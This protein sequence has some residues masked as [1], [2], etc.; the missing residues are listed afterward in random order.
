MNSAAPVRRTPNSPSQS[1][2]LPEESASYD[3]LPPPPYV[4]LAY[5][6]PVPTSPDVIH[7]GHRDGRRSPDRLSK[8]R[9]S[10]FLKQS[11]GPPGVM[12]PPAYVANFGAVQ[13]YQHQTLSKELDVMTTR[14]INQVL[15]ELTGR[16]IRTDEVSPRDN[17]AGWCRSAFLLAT[18]IVA[19]AMGSLVSYYVV[20]N[21]VIDSDIK[22]GNSSNVIHLR[23]DLGVITVSEHESGNRTT[24]TS[25]KASRVFYLN[26][27]QEE[28]TL[29]FTAKSLVKKARCRSELCRY[30]TQR[31]KSSLNW[32]I[33]PCKDFYD[34]VCASWKTCKSAVLSQDSA[35]V[36]EIQNTL[37]RGLIQKELESDNRSAIAHARELFSLCVKN[38]SSDPKLE[39]KELTTLLETVGL[40]NW[41]YRNDTLSRADFWRTNAMLYRHLDLSALVSVT[42]ERDPDNDTNSIIALDE[43]DLLIGL[44]GTKEAYLPNWYGDV[45][46]VTMKL[47][48]P[49]KYLAH[50]QS[51]LEFSEKLSEITSS[52]GERNYAEEAKISTIQHF[53]SYAQFL[54]FIFDEIAPVTERTRI[55]VKNVRY[56]KALKSLLHVTQNCVVLNYLGFRA[57]LHISPLLLQEGFS[58]LAA[59]RMRQLTGVEDHKWPRWQTCLRVIDSVLPTVYLQYYRKVVEKKVN[60]EKVIALLN[61]M[62]S[63]LLLGINDLTWMS[64]ESKVLS[65]NVLSELKLEAFFP[66]WFTDKDHQVYPSLAETNMLEVYRTHAQRIAEGHLLKVSANDPGRH[67]EWRGTIFDTHPT[68]DYE[69]RTVFV[70]VGIFNFS[71]PNTDAALLIQIPRIATRVLAA[72]I[73]SL[74]RNFYPLPQELWLLNTAASIKEKQTCLAAQ[75]HLISNSMH[76]AKVNS[77]V[78]TSYDF[79]DNAALEP[80]MKQ[81]LKYAKESGIDI[82]KEVT[83]LPLNAEQL[84]HALFALEMC[85]K[86]GAEQLRRELT[87]DAF[88]QPKLRVNVPLRNNEAFARAWRCGQN[89]SMV[90]AERC[91][92]WA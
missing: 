45:V 72:M 43:P 9:G 64:R 67:P 89:D 49:Q 65:K 25:T 40:E 75:Y 31:L 5:C 87:E 26:P 78:T 70:P 39:W 12:L 4:P 30:E 46:R 88:T 59:V 71:Y 62:K 51:V 50:A 11:P 3:D 21:G 82:P 90:A 80:A 37:K 48:A 53:H 81:F 16:P 6:I 76:D 61:D 41:P 56:L 42:V 52:R 2:S 66:S 14:R 77:A 24:T 27:T 54:G 74:H 69:T 63:S 83:T 73:A 22:I 33:S 28:D 32:T 79:L 15:A 1:Q 19:M 17:T 85:E 13:P 44:F 18:V 47:F 55:L 8:K 57:V 58:D 84:F 91:K 29:S 7:M 86:G 35:Y 68:F 38:T 20:R 36:E 23:G 10:A 34:F 60:T 92:L